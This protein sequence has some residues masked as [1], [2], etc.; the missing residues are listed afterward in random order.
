MAAYGYNLV[1]RVT[2]CI[3]TDGIHFVNDFFVN[4]DK[5]YII[6]KDA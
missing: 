2:M 5:L 6:H 1:T 4:H 3:L